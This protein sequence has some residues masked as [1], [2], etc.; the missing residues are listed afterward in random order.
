MSEIKYPF[1]DYIKEDKSK[2]KTATEAGFIDP[3]NDFLIGESGGFLLNIGGWKFID[4]HLFQEVGNIYRDHNR[5]TNFKVDSVPYEKFRIREE[6]RRI[7]GYTLPCRLNSDGTISKVRITGEHYNFLNYCPILKLDESS[8][9]VGN[10][11][12]SASKIKDFPNFI[13]AQYW[14]FKIR[15]FVR[16]NGFHLIIDKT[17]RAGFSYIDGTGSAHAIN[18]SPHKTIIHAASDNKYLVQSGGL[19]DFTKNQIN[20]YEQNTPFKRGIASPTASDLRLGYKNKDQ[21]VEGWM[22]ACI[23]V[24]AFNNPDC[25]IGKD[26]KEIKCEELSMFDNFDDFM[27]VTEPACRT[28]AFVTGN[29][30]AWGTGGSK[31]SSWAVFEANFYNPTAYKFMPFENV[32]DK[33]SRNK[34]CGYFK[35]YCWGLQGVIDGKYAMDKDGNSDLVV[36]LRIAELER[37]SA[38]VNAKTYSQFVTYCGQY[39]V[40]PCESFSSVSENPFSGE[41]LDTWENKLKMDEAYS[42]HTDG[43]LIESVDDKGNIKVTF[44]SNDKIREDGGIFNKDFYDYIASCPRNSNEH[45]HGCIRKWF[46]PRYLVDPAT[47]AKYIPKGL[48]SISYDPVGIDKANK[49]IT[50]KHSHNSIAV[51]ENPHYSN[52]FKSRMVMTY[53]GRPERLEEADRICL[54]MAIFYNCEGNV[55]AEVNRGETISNFTKWKALKYLAKDPKYLWDNTTV[56]KEE[57]GYGIVLNDGSTKLEAIRMLR[58]YL[59]EVMGKDSYDQDILGMHGIFDH[60]TILEIKKWSS[61]GNFDRVSQLLVRAIEWK[62]KDIKAT[63]IVNDVKRNTVETKD[64]ILHRAWF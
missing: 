44:K 45:P 5:Y 33:D 20:F 27:D 29:I 61:T 41:S 22:S 58:E 16:N 26:A 11:A 32:W 28:G 63:K 36:G 21:I 57:G 53:Y 4:T 49:E 46:N 62:A 7:E 48:Y 64:S 54:L 9:K 1:L 42:F 50:L 47:G 8:I 56:G 6:R 38:R 17:R 19:S 2:Y 3:D 39:A 31:S 30:F 52:G 40:M 37:E 59:Y 14:Y 18:V 55:W 35:P 10:G 13:D 43:N 60:V 15:E 51:W 12:N 25:A 23:S 34:L 24:S